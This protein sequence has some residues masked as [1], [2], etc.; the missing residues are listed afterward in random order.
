MSL[1]RTLRDIV[2]EGGE[3][4]PITLI[5]CPP[6]FNLRT[7]ATTRETLRWLAGYGASPPDRYLDDL[8]I[9][10]ATLCQKY[11]L[12][13]YSLMLL[14]FIHYAFENYPLFQYYAL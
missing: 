9:G 5:N 4:D 8:V 11:Y 7:V 10:S 2:A 13:C 12:L 14:K 1:E 6:T 3:Q